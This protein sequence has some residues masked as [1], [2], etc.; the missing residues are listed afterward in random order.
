LVMPETWPMVPNYRIRNF[1][2]CGFMLA[3]RLP[4]FITFF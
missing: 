4:I 1:M 2:V 3:G